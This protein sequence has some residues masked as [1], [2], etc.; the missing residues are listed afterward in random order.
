MIELNMENYFAS[1]N[2]N[3]KLTYRKKL[4]LE[5]G[6]TLLNL[7]SLRNGLKMLMI[8]LKFHGKM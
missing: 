5:S 6:E 4:M 8:F 7:Y 1:L 2:E 3:D